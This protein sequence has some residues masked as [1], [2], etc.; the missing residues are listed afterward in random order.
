MSLPLTTEE[1]PWHDPEGEEKKGG[2]SGEVQPAPAA[3]L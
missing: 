1:W 2:K 3:V